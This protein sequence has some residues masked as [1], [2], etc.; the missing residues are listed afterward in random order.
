MKEKERFI[1]L[2]NKYFNISI[3]LYFMKYAS[4]SEFIN[5]HRIIFEQSLLILVSLH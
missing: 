1:I 5:Q 4:S 2:K 3:N